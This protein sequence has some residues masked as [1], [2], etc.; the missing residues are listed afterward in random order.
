MLGGVIASSLY[1]FVEVALLLSSSLL[2]R[3][4]FQSNLE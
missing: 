4:G 3:R 1:R 2:V